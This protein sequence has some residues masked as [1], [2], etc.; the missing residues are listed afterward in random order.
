[1]NM[2]LTLE[3]F[4]EKV[5]QIPQLT[6]QKSKNGDYYY[7]QAIGD[8]PDVRKYLKT[9]LK[10][11]LNITDC[12]LLPKHKDGGVEVQNKWVKKEKIDNIVNAIKNAT[13]YEELESLVDGIYIYSIDIKK[14]NKVVSGIRLEYRRPFH[15]VKGSDLITNKLNKIDG[16]SI[17]EEE[18]ENGMIVLIQIHSINQKAMCRHKC[19]TD[20]AISQIDEVF[21]I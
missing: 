2:N 16:I 18:G 7:W 20:M 10:T 19:K 12:Y 5:E 6:F 9:I 15:N 14:Q 4:K 1:M 17:K 3:E 11:K 13:S 21:G 8:N